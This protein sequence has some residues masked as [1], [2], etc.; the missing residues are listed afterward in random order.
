LENTVHIQQHLQVLRSELF[1]MSGLTQRAVDYSIK[2]YELG[3]REFCRYVRKSEHEFDELQRCVAQLCHELLATGL[4]VESEARFVWCALQVC[5]SLGATH[6][7]ATDIAQQTTRFLEGGA[8][9]ESPALE[10]TGRV[11]NR[12]V[13]LSTIALRKEEVRHAEVVLQSRGVERWFKLAAYHGSGGN[14][15]RI[16]ARAPFELAITRNLSQIAKQTY[17]IAYAITVWL[18]GK[19]RMEFTSGRNFTRELLS[20]ESVMK[21]VNSFSLW[22]DASLQVKTCD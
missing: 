5:S 1:E 16:G 14:D 20:A 12:L 19:G 2:A 13:R 21:R 7:A 8:V 6:A 15:Q 4:P 3:S 10:A 11:V 17:D 18:E 9:F 22:P